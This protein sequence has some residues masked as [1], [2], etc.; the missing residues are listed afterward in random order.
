MRWQLAFCALPLMPGLRAE[1]PCA[2]TPM[3]TPCEIVVEMA[4]TEAPKHPNPF[5]SVQLQ[6]EIRS[7]KYKTYLVPGFWDGGRRFAIRFAPDEAGAW[8]YRLTSNLEGVTGKS[9]TFQGVAS[10]SAGFIRP[11]NLHHWRYTESAKAHLWMGDT[12][13]RFATMDRAVFDQMV[14]ARAAQKF[15]HVRGLLLPDGEDAKRAFAAADAPVAAYFQE[16]DS[17]LA[18]LNQKGLIVDL[19]LG[20]DQNQLARLFPS[21]AE[22]ERYL[23]YVVA[24]YAAYNITWQLVQEYEEYENGRELMKQLGLTLKKLDYYDHPRTTHTTSTSSPLLADGWETHVLNQSSDLALEAIEHQL[25]TVPFVNAEFAY[26]DSGAGKKQPHHVDADEFRRRLWGATMNGQY[27][28]FG[29]TG[30]YGGRGLPVEAKYLESAGAKTMTAWFEIM[31][32]TR[33][34]DLDPYFDLE[35]GRA[36]ALPDVE[37]LVYLQ[38]PGPVEVTVEK[39]EYQVYWID[40]ATGESTKQKKDFKGDLFQGS[41]PD[42]SHDWLLHLS[43]DGRK[44]GMNKSYYFESR[45]VPVQ[46]VEVSP[47]KVPYDLA[48]P[49]AEELPVGQPVKFAINLKRETRATRS[50]QYVIAG[51]VVRDAQGGRFLAS[52]KE[53]AFTVPRAMV[54]SLPATL[55]LRVYGLNAAGKLYAQDHIFELKAP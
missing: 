25:F 3:Y 20:G 4:A 22:R 29:N 5:L 54:K 32:R 36:M 49:H 24:R 28:T 38:K 6:A 33:W 50:M 52:G 13:Y 10:E 51:E 18:A 34:W 44:E 23:R 27:P 43:R 15:N 48:A 37:Y 46:E 30:S 21:Y 7:P 45:P 41:P 11:A 42:T 19:I 2:A 9:G 16:V 35:G 17:R 31:S 1:Q 40:P 47:A 26:E 8:T 12:S 14:T 39:H 55:S 53:G